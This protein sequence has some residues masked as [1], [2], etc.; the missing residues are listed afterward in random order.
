[1]MGDSYRSRSN[2]VIFTNP[3]VDIFFAKYYIKQLTNAIVLE[4]MKLLYESHCLSIFNETIAVVI[5]MC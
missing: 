4:K 2:S 1:M 5:L 3:V